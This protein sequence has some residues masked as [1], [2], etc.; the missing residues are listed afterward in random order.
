LDSQICGLLG[1]CLR[2]AMLS[3]EQ[4]AVMTAILAIGND[5]RG[6]DSWGYYNMAEV[7]KGLGD[8]ADHALE[9]FKNNFVMAHTRKATQGTVSVEN[10]HPF[11]VGI[12]LG[13]ITESFQTTTNLT[14]SISASVRWI[15]NTFSTI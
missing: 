5:H 6:G 15:H 1:F 12:S 2:N 11:E 7:T 10:A 3:R 9:M 14:Q 13:R 8:L 4:K